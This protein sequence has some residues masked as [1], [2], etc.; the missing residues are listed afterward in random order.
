LTLEQY[1]EAKGLPQEFLC[2]IGLCTARHQKQ[3]AVEMPYTDEEG[4]VVA[5]RYRTSLERGEDID[6]R[7]RWRRGDKPRLYGLGRLETAR[8]A[9]F[10]VLVEGESDCHT[11][12]FAGLP[13]LGVPGATMWR[14]EWATC[15]GGIRKVYLVVEPDE[16]GH[17]LRADVSASALRDRLYLVHLPGCKDPSELHLADPQGFRERFRVVLEQAT[18]LRHEL[19]AEAKS[20]WEAAWEQCQLLAAHPDILER[21]AQDLKAS[22]F[23]G[24][25][26]VAKLLFLVLITR[27][28]DRPV[29]AAIKGPSSAGKSFVIEQ[30]LKF[31]PTSTHYTL[32]AM[33]ERALAYSKEPLAHRFLVIIEATGMSGDMQSYLVRSLL[34]EG[35]LRYETVEKTGKGLQPRVIEREGPTGLIVTTTAVKLHPENETRFFSLT[36]TDTTEQTRLV[37]LAQAQEPGSA[38]VDHA[39]W[40]ALQEWLDSAERTAIIPYA[41]AIARLLPTHAVRLR[42][43]FPALLSLI[44]AHALLH[45]AGREKDTQGAVIAALSDYDMVRALV[46]EA[47]SE[48]IEAAVPKAV[49][50]TVEALEELTDEEGGAEGT[51][52]VSR[53]AQH[54]GLDK[55]TVSRR[56]KRATDLGFVVNDE[57]QKGKPAKLHPAEPMP[58]DR[59]VLPTAGE[60]EEECCT[61]AW[62]TRRLSLPIAMQQCNT[63][64]RAPT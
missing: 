64:R 60:V 44:R 8:Q 42:R 20:H 30:V 46:K 25:T 26:N 35:R 22:G 11:L 27:L 16:G 23:A 19:E 6:N 58:A 32:T 49:R 15:F 29:S 39:P 55:T 52:S 33:S 50:E 14:D 47:F 53:L 56:V 10:I 45:Q 36:V 54:L 43:D 9:G 2:K 37:L 7:F 63:P 34:S 4:T 59:D 40:H 17:K 51:V 3:P 57:E 5:K 61:V 12:W 41:S 38:I 31:F 18:P 1:A 24:D 48:G 21:F 13:A 62:N 28:L